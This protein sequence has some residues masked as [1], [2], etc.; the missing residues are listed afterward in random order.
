MDTVIAA[1]KAAALAQLGPGATE[2]DLMDGSYPS[3]WF[4]DIPAPPRYMTYAV[5]DVHN[6]SSFRRVESD[7]TIRQIHTDEYYASLGQPGFASPNHAYGPG[8][9]DYGQRGSTSTGGVA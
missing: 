7:G 3:A 1:Q 6:P 2:Q 4:T 9:G 5:G 8:I